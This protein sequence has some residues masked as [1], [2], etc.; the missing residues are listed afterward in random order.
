MYGERE[1]ERFVKR[2]QVLMP[3]GR[4]SP[5]PAV[6]KQETQESQSDNESLRLSLRTREADEPN[7][8]SEGRKR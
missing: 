5:A 6:C 2:N 8:Q 3:S 7:P 1:R 4:L